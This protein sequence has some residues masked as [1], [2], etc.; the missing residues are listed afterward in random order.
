MAAEELKK[1]GVVPDV[2]QEPWQEKLEVNYP[3]SNVNADNGNELTPTDVRYKPDLSWP[4][5][6]N[7]LYV[8]CMTDPDAPSRK[9]PK[10]REWLHWLVGNIPGKSVKDGQSLAE[11]VGS[12]PPKGSG[13]HRYVLLVYKQP[14]K[15]TFS[16]PKIS[17]TATA[18]RAKFSIAKFA[19][20]YD[21]G[22]PIAGNFFQAQYDS[23]CDAI[24][25][26]F[27]K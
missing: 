6:E 4:V 11:Y 22:N 12:V 26:S 15:I 1:H 7:A 2:I 17:E 27:K 5:E 8:I 9:D 10:A 19:R 24:Y 13:L 23:T 25:Q 3:K 16:E 20:K 14:K 21:L 18:G